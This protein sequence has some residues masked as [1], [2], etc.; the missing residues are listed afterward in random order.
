[1]DSVLSRRVSLIPARGLPAIPSPTI[2]GATGDRRAASGFSPVPTGFVFPSRLARV[3]RPKRVH[4]VSVS[5]DLVTDGSFSPCCSPPRLAATQLRFD[6]PRLVA[7]GKRTSTVPSAPSQAHG[8][9]AV[10][11]AAPLLQRERARVRRGNS[12]ALLRLAARR[13]RDRDAPPPHR[14]SHRRR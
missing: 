1:M 2:G 7:A 8:G 5:R 13:A 3:H 10:P 4:L 12:R 14:N 9:V 6:T 11:A